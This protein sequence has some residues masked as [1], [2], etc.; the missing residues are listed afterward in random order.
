M[1]DTVNLVKSL[2][3][4]LIGPRGNLV[5]SFFYMP[6]LSICF[7]N[8]YNLYPQI[9]TALNPG[10]RSFFLQ[11]TVLNTELYNWSKWQKISECERSGL[12]GTIIIYITVYTTTKTQGALTGALGQKTW[13]VQRNAMKHRVLDTT[14]CCSHKTTD[15]GYPT[16]SKSTQ[17]Q[18]RQNSSTSGKAFR[19]SNPYLKITG[20][21]WDCGHV[22]SLT[23]QWIATPIHIWA[24]LSGLKG[25]FQ[26]E[27]SVG[28][29]YVVCV[30]MWTVQKKFKGRLR[31]V[32]DQI[33]K[34]KEDV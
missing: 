21:C 5:L 14:W 2:S 1:P 25:L 34:N 18:V 3:R 13:T 24:P 17:D 19:R 22:K 33:L 4:V 6:T 20:N 12:N 27:V 15:C 11:C 29:D 30:Y 23:F 16:C 28:V 7:L 31:G 26:K 32:F 9:C 8:V 10:Q